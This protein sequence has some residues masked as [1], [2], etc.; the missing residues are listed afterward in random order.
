MKYEVCINMKNDNALCTISMLS[1]M[2][3][4]QDG[5]YYSLL[6]PFVLHSLPELKDSEISVEKVTESMRK[7][8]FTDFP[9]KLTETI[10]SKL[11]TKEVDKQIFVRQQTKR[12]KKKFFVNTV[13]DRSSFDARQNGMR[14]KI[15]DILHAIQQYFE[16]HFYHKKLPLDSI[17]DKLTSFLRLTVLL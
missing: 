1:A 16:E 11:C 7:F 17:R 10:L 13:F 8:G 4:T 9:H 12:G 15:D 3:E 2:L 5:S 14:K 6:I